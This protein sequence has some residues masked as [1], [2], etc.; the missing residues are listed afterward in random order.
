MKMDSVMEDCDW[1]PS[2]QGSCW[3]LSGLKVVVTLLLFRREEE[4]EVVVAR[5]GDS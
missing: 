1:S 4:G 5:P 2:S 3:W